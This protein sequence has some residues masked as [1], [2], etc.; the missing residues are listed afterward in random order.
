MS[1]KARCN[2]HIVTSVFK[3]VQNNALDLFKEY[4]VK[5]LHNYSTRHNG[6]DIIVPKVSTESVKKGCYF[7]GAPVF[8]NLP[9]SMKEI[10]SLLIFKTLIKDFYIENS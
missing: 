9:S 7:F 3:C 6:L 8:N 5:T 1:L 4:F 2:M 10:K